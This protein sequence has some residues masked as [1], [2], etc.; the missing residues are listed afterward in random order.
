MYE[1]CFQLN[2][3]LDS[4]QN[5]KKLTQGFFLC[6]HMSKIKNISDMYVFTHTAACTLLSILEDY[7]HFSSEGSLPSL[8]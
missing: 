5:G 2:C 4:S 8:N 1:I 6:C 7:T 3:V